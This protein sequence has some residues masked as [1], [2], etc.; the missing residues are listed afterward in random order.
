M[1]ITV[2]LEEIVYFICP[3]TIDRFD[4]R[5]CVLDRHLCI[6]VLGKILFSHM[7]FEFRFIFQCSFGRQHC[8]I[9]RIGNLNR[10]FV[11][12]FGN[13]KICL[14]EG[15]LCQSGNLIIPDTACN[16]IHVVVSVDFSGGICRPKID[17][18]NIRGMV[19]DVVVQIVD[20]FLWPLA[21]LR[22]IERL[23]IY[24]I[25]LKNSC[26]VECDGK[27]FLFCYCCHGII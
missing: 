11:L 16:G 18:R 12:F 10:P 9:C 19:V 24:R 22:R 20:D 17:K 2:H 4:E 21:C 7:Y 5:L 15:R 8:S 13:R 23:G 6:V 25:K 27:S 1:F 26:V 3:G 14:F